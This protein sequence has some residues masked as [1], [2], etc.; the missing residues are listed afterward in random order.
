MQKFLEAISTFITLANQKAEHH[1]G[2]CGDVQEEILHTL[3]HEFSDLPAGESF[4]V[5]HKAGTII[6]VLGA[7]VDLGDG[8]AELWG[9]FV[10][11][12]QPVELALEL[13]EDLTM[14][15]GDKV[16]TYHGFYN[17]QNTLARNF[18]NKVGACKGSQHLIMHST[19]QSGVRIDSSIDELSPERHPSFIKLHDEAF[20][21]TYMSGLEILKR[22]DYEHKVFAVESEAGI[23]GYAYVSGKP[24]Y[25]EGTIE[26]IAVNPA[27]RQQ[28]IGTALT[29][30]ALAFLQDELGIQTVSMTVDAGHEQAIR[31]YGRAG[32]EV[33]HRMEHY[34]VR[35][36]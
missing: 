26:F 3:T 10:E 27:E 12:G 30:T 18:M 1:V 9:P 20:P 5:I 33:V 4:A 2:Y 35:V 8:T 21:E 31:L 7:D 11:E 28:G 32:F 29:K 23:K 6:G 13:W 14:R 36:T 16:H 17:E 15:L 24:T 22:L 19:K 34:V 25:N